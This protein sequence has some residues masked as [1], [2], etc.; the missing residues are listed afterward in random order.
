[1]AVMDD[2]SVNCTDT[3]KLTKFS[4]SV[5]LRQLLDIGSANAE[6]TK[7]EKYL[8]AQNWSPFIVEKCL[9]DVGR[10]ILCGK[11]DFMDKIVSIFSP[12]LIELLQRASCVQMSPEVKHHLMCSLFGKLITR[13]K[14]VLQ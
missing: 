2:D 11:Y 12:I 9:D 4:V 1:M 7:L 8:T 5:A 14:G 10:L 13:N 3:E 6:I